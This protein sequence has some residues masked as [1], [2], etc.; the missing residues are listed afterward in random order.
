[1]GHGL[2][3]GAAGSDQ[4]PAVHHAAHRRHRA[5]LPLELDRRDLPLQSAQRARLLVF[6]AR[7]QDCRRLDHGAAVEA[8]AGRH[9][10][11]QL[12]RPD[13]GVPRRGRSLSLARARRDPD[14]ALAGAGQR[15]PERRRPARHARS[16]GLYRARHRAHRLAQGHRGRGGRRAEGNSRPCARCSQGLHR[17]CAP[18]GDRRPRRRTRRG[19]GHGSHAVRRQDRRDARGRVPEAQ[20]HP[21]QPPLAAGHG[22]RAV[23]RPQ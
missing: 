5:A 14:A 16:A 8:G 13:Q 15:Q 6:A 12:R 2:L 17:P 10:R 9:R 1:M 23:L 7:S 11:D 20:V 22:D 19:A 18:A 4:S 3:G 21:R